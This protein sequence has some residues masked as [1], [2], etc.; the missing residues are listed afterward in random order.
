MTKYF[1]FGFSSYYCDVAVVLAASVYSSLMFDE[2]SI[3]I[4]VHIIDK[5]Q[6]MTLDDLQR[7]TRATTSPQA[8]QPPQHAKCLL[9]N[10]QSEF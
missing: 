2:K 10:E 4:I 1:L 9:D 6:S 7:S 3:H 5:Y 8:L